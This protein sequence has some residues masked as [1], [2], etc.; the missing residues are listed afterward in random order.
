MVGNFPERIMAMVVTR[1]P[2]VRCLCRH[3]LPTIQSVRQGH[4]AVKPHWEEEVRTRDQR[5]PTV[6]TVKPAWM[7][8]YFKNELKIRC[9]Q[10][11]DESED[12]SWKRE[13]KENAGL[14][15][16]QN[17]AHNYDYWIVRHHQPMILYYRLEMMV[18]RVNYL[19]SVGLDSRQKLRHIQKYPPTLVFSFDSSDYDANLVYLRGLTRKEDDF[20]HLFHPVCDKVDSFY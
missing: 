8:N 17:I 14:E 20:I 15:V 1:N 9:V 2:L 3:Y 6:Y 5:Y 13:N 7:Y 18:Q 10:E 19:S 4:I 16:I 12:N 11:L